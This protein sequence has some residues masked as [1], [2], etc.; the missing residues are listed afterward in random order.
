MPIVLPGPAVAQNL[1]LWGAVKR[2]AI[3]FAL[4]ATPDPLVMFYKKPADAPSAA[5]VLEKLRKITGF[6]GTDV[7]IGKVD[8]DQ[9]ALRVVV[10]RRRS[11]GSVPTE[12]NFKRVWKAGVK[13][14][15]A[16]AAG[17]MIDKAVFGEEA[18]GD[19]VELVTVDPVVVEPPVGATA[20][21]TT[22]S[23]K[24]A[25]QNNFA[26]L[27]DQRADVTAKLAMVMDRI[28]EAPSAKQLDVLRVLVARDLALSKV[29]VADA[30]KSPAQDKFDA[31]DTANL[32]EG[33]CMEAFQK[34]GWF[35]FKKLRKAKLNIQLDGVDAP[36]TDAMMWRLY[37]YRRH[38]VDGLI[39]VLHSKYAGLIF[40]SSGSED[41][42]SD[43]DITVGSPHSGDDVLAMREFNNRVK[44]DLGKP[45]GRV[46]DV[47]LY[48]R[49]WNAIKDNLTPDTRQKTTGDHG[50]AEPESPAMRRLANI[51]QDVATL[52]KQRRY[53][54]GPEFTVMWKGLQDAMP[55]K[56]EK[57]QIRQRFEEAEDVYLLTANEKVAEIVKLIDASITKG[58]PA[59][60]T[61]A[62][63]V[64][65]YTKVKARWEKAR[66]DNDYRAVQV[67]LEELLDF[68]EEEFPDEVM[69]ATDTMYADRMDD[70][71]KVQ[72]EIEQRDHAIALC[73]QTHPDEDH[74]AWSLSSGLDGLKARVKQTQFTN[75]VFANEAYISQGAITHIVA[76]NQSK[77]PEDKARVLAALKPQELMQSAN[78]QMADFYK[79]MKHMSHVEAHAP[80]GT[81]KRRATG[82][83]FV[84]ASKYLHRVLDAV[85]TL[86]DK[87]TANAEILAQL[88]APAFTICQG[89]T[90]AEL[91]DWVE[92]KLLALRKSSSLPGNVKSEVAY[93][94]VKKMFRVETVEGLKALVKDFSVEFNKR[95]RGIA[96]MQESQSVDTEAER[97]YFRGGEAKLAQVNREIA[98]LSETLRK[99][100]LLLG[101]EPADEDRV[102][103]EVGQRNALKKKEDLERE[104]AVLQ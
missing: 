51:D 62:D 6:R 34:Y 9:G 33:Q 70:L 66:T 80:A 103:L 53:L 98:T 15:G 69:D 13:T 52:M 27:T 67:L 72:A 50:I 75:I 100:A 7:C 44:T 57:D 2:S 49:D 26:E 83:A 95:V 19:V 25:K 78:E 89:M 36:F 88:Q 46:F 81:E 22:V 5:K 48:A 85:V 12:A 56:E 60:P 97:A 77:T 45:P 91:R 54:S 35:E 58:P 32:S 84:H 20:P 3:Q 4:V 8:W 47:N 55:T 59:P 63:K 40:K 87:Y 90:A 30:P 39:E 10:D 101:R 61:P 24:P 21:E 18:K 99:I 14:G 17:A 23:L 104:L 29:A 65:A 94:E 71:R 82:E 42:E 11:K 96:E 41:I 64:A 37:Q 86:E 38:Y 92:S 73:D 102:K 31:A 1:A 43:F 76:G 68:S 28:G 16:I 79:D 74:A 93:D